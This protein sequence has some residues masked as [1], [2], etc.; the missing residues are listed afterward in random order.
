MKRAW[1]TIRS[2]LLWA[3]SLLNFGISVPILV[4][5][6]FVFDPKKHDWLQRAFCRRIIFFAGAH[7]KVVTS[8]GF[9]PK[10]TCIF[11]SNHVNFFDPF[12]LYCA[13]PQFTRGW[14]LESHF[15]IPIYGMLMKR[16]GNVPVPDVRRPS[17]LKRLWRLTKDAIDSGMSLIVFPEGR[18]TRNGRVDEFELGAFRLAQ[19]LDIPLVPVSIVGSFQHHATGNWMFRPAEITI[20]LHDT[21]DLSNL[22]KEDVPALRDRVHALVSRPVDESLNVIANQKEEHAEETV[23]N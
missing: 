14:E 13:I 6:A 7:V 16:F 20:H 22:L 18:R 21:M 12:V 3:V 17:D 4:V 2:A 5:L 1:L 15:K 8:P 23:T 9:D 10:R 11:I 19:Q